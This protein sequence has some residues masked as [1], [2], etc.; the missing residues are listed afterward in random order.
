MATD[1]I[2]CVQSV[3][4]VKVTV[5][6]ILVLLT[7]ILC[8]SLVTWFRKKVHCLHFRNDF[9]KFRLHFTTFG[10]FLTLRISNI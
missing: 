3:V 10:K 8:L 2:L 7:Y 5:S 6:G 4:I 1:S 9:A